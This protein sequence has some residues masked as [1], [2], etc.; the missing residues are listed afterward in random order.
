M[1][2]CVF[3]PDGT[4]VS[5]AKVTIKSACGS[6]HISVTKT[7]DSQGFFDIS[8]VDPNC[9]KV[10]IFASKEGDYWLETC[11][12]SVLHG[13][14]SFLGALEKNGI[15]PIVNFDEISKEPIHV[16]LGEQGGRIRVK[17]LDL[18]TGKYLRAYVQIEYPPTGFTVFGYSDPYASAFEHLLP[19]GSY[20]ATAHQFQYKGVGYRI[21]KSKKLTF[22]VKQHQDKEVILH[23]DT[24]KTYPELSHEFV[25]PNGHAK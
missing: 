16:Y 21:P 12:D 18:A 19:S 25:I 22:I 7:S 23:V 20:I 17:V 11:D 2:G 6:R 1:R 10:V 3:Y 15:V 14:C 9:P 13:R 5:E 4:P 8:K 24:R